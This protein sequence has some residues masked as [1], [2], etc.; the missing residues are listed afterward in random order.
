MVMRYPCQPLLDDPR[1]PF[2]GSPR[3]AARA[4][5]PALAREGQQALVTAIGTADARESVH[6]VA[7]IQEPGY[8]LLHDGSEGTQLMLE[9]FLVDSH[10][11]IPVILEQSVQGASG[12]PPRCVAQSMV[13]GRV[14]RG[15]VSRPT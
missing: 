3:L 7:A 12:E 9:L 15:R 13:R 6:R 10:E 11:G 5:S 14:R 8:H 2:L 4:E 1:C